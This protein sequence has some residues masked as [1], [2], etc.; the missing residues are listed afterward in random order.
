MIRPSTFPVIG[1]LLLLAVASVGT[2]AC[3]QDRDADFCRD[4]HLIHTDH[5]DSIGHLTVDLTAAGRMT[6]EL[7]LPAAFTGVELT[8]DVF[9]L[10]ADADC[11]AADPMVRQTSSGLVVTFESDCGEANRLRQLDVSVFDLLPELEEIEVSMSTPVTQKRFAINRQC[12]N[13]IF[14]LDRRNTQQ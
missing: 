2:V 10:Q 11:T 8:D 9:G 14:R 3:V 1:R 6:K 4:H 7:R 13:P 5:I 12:K